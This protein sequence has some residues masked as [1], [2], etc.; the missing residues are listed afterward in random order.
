MDIQGKVK[1]DGVQSSNEIHV[2]NKQNS[3][4]INS[5]TGGGDGWG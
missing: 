4:Y 5:K 1:R 2:G 3:F